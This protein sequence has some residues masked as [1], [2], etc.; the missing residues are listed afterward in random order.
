MYESHFGFTEKPFSIAPNPRYLYMSA[1]H[2]EAMA[3]LLYGIGEGGGFVQLTGEVGTGKT[4]LCR[5]LLGEVPPDVDVA[6]ILNPRI[7]ELELMQAICDELRI[8]YPPDASI[9]KLLDRLNSHLLEVHAA[10]R[11]TVL[12][13]DEAQNLSVAVLE[14]VRL[15]TNL[16]TTRR[17]LLQ[18]ILIGQPELRET[19]AQKSLRQ[20]SQ[21]ITAR[22][23]LRPLNRREMRDY[24]NH[25][26]KQAGC[27]RRLFTRSAA[28]RIYRASG[29]VPRLANVI[30]DRALLGA[31][32]RGRQT[33]SAATASKA[34]REVRGLPA[35]RPLRWAIWLLLALGLFAGPV[36]AYRM[37]WLPPG[38]AAQIDQLVPP[39]AKWSAIG[40]QFAGWAMT[41]AHAAGSDPVLEMQL[42]PL[43]AST[44]RALDD[45][46]RLGIARA[47]GAPGGDLDAFI[48]GI[49][50]GPA[51]RVEAL[52]TLARV[53][54]LPENLVFDCVT[55]REFGLRC[56]QFD[57]DWRELVA[58]DRPA[59]VELAAEDGAGHAVLRRYDGASVTLESGSATVS[60]PWTEF[61]ERWSGG[62][63]IF[64][65]QPPVAAFPIGDAAPEGDLLWL[66]RALNLEALNYGGSELDA[67]DLAI[68]DTPLL[69]RLHDFQ[70]RAGLELR[71]VA[72]E[73]ELVV[74][75][76]RLGYV[77]APSLRR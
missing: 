33:V 57:S 30:C 15:L 66:R 64:W 52:R 49:E 4:T 11:H 77:D 38:M 58:L 53:W 62:G 39:W 8:D 18:I 55:V 7:D 23:H 16:E 19:L 29:G 76:R 2:R 69:D 40:G 56:Y 72:A 3:H 25:R 65:R 46:G 50:R 22:Y 13:I 60:V 24:I 1:H 34:A 70:S 67:V 74:L 61:A 47:A 43:A 6:L 12:I 73:A 21:R 31:Y 63:T 35:R 68:F 51:N 36:A 75:N 71:D 48:A 32:T 28:R 59:V 10:G 26:L 41:P 14:Q 20:L 44:R 37:G 5:Q 42:D 9:K 45:P 54:G 17:K 27:E